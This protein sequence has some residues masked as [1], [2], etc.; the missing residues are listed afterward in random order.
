MDV[1]FERD[2][3][4]MAHFLDLG[5]RIA[6]EGQGISAATLQRVGVHPFDWDAFDGG[7]F[8]GS[9]S[10]LESSADVPRGNIIELFFVEVCQDDGFLSSPILAKMDISSTQCPDRAIN[11]VPICLLIDA[12]SLPTILLVVQFHGG[13]IRLRN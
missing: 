7:L 6:G 11:G 13:A 2:P 3:V 9:C 12:D 4:P 8:E 5:V 1:F 10:L